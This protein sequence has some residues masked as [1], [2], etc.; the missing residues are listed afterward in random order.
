M[1]LFVEEPCVCVD[2]DEAEY[3]MWGLSAAAGAH[4]GLLNMKSIR[5]RRK[6]NG[7]HDSFEEVSCI[8]SPQH[9]LTAAE[10]AEY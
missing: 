2:M 6:G 3:S 1:N 7:S 4:T 8:Y 9:L 10:S 5:N